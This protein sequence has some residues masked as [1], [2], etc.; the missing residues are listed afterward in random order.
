MAA[1][2]LTKGWHIVGTVQESVRTGLHDLSDGHPGRVEIETLD[3]TEPDQIAALRDRLAG[4]SFDIL[5]HNAGT[6]NR[7]PG[8]TIADISTEEFVRVMV[9]NALSPM[10]VI[11]RL[12][13]LVPADG[14]IGIMSSGQGS[15]SNNTKGGAEI[16]RGSKAALNMFMPQL[17]SPPR[18]R[19]ARIAADGA[20]LDSHRTRR[21][22]RDLQHRG[23]HSKG[24]GRAALAAGQTRPALSRPRRGAPFR[25]DHR[26]D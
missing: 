2:L 4:R 7:N 8:D 24:R 21:A 9:T 23:K 16:Y 3:V 18:R 13:D 6:A 17:R 14:M 11:E 19:V 10:R 26:P 1:E 25:G 20:R 15:I 22:E 5:F 12:Q